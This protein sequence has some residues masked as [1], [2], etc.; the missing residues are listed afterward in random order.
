MFGSTRTACSND[1]D[2]PT[3]TDAMASV[4][5]VAPKL[6]SLTRLIPR[7]RRSTSAPSQ[8]AITREEHHK[9][10][11]RRRSE[12][13][14]GVYARGKPPLARS[15]GSWSS[16]RAARTIESARREAVYLDMLERFQ[17]REVPVSNRSRSGAVDPHERGEFDEDVAAS[18]TEVNNTCAQQPGQQTWRSRAKL[19]WRQLCQRFDC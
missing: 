6:A 7:V 10:P 16:R 4:T 5:R 15:S 18:S 9:S 8:G 13:A 12:R 17:V 3:P 11:Q 14:K 2:A 19:R 1:A